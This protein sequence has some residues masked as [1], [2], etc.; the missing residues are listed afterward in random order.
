[1]RNVPIPPI[2]KVWKQAMMSHH[3]KA[4]YKLNLTE[5]QFEISNYKVKNHIN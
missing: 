5:M 3:E 1:M 4:S 2:D